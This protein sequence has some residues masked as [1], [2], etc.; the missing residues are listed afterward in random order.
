MHILRRKTFEP[1]KLVWPLAVMMLAVVA[2]AWGCS[3]DAPRENECPDTPHATFVLTLTAQDGVIPEDTWLEVKYGS[4]TERFEVQHPNTRGQVVF[5][6]VLRI[7][8]G[9]VGDAMP[10]GGAGGL[11]PIEKVRCRLWTDGP[12]HVTAKG[13][14]YPELQEDIAPEKDECGIKQTEV[15]L[16]LRHEPPQ[17]RD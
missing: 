1:A 4:G 11:G 5:C 7:G 9:G 16:E 14:D 13:G 10:E 2:G 15:Q 12:A 17:D 8:Q 6:Q 3:T